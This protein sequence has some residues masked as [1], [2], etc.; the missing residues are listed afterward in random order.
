MIRYRTRDL[1]RLVP[2]PCPCGRTFMRMQRVMGRTD[3]MLIIKGVN[4]FPVQIEKVLFEIE[5]TEPHYQIIVE[6]ENHS[7]KVTVL[8]EV[9]ES[10]FF[11][12]M[13]KQRGM[14]D[15]IKARLASEL[16][17]GVDV[18]LVEEKTLERFEGK[19]KRVIDKRKL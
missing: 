16:G 5:G 19:S 7:D 18:R 4:V 15:H 10:I 8:V 17:I 11:D 14:V 6:R 2:E 12:E 1:T 13:K 3:D 9:V